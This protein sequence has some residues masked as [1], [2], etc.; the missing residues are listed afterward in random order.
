MGIERNHYR[1][2]DPDSGELLAEG[3]VSECAEKLGMTIDRFRM[4]AFEY[5]HGKYYKYD[6]L[7]VTGS[8]D[9]VKKHHA[10][11]IKAWDKFMTPIREYYGI[12]VYKPD[13]EDME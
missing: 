6:I 13:K 11:A 7:N 3:T 5:S 1:V 4:A 10:A 2:Y 8:K 12:P 9:D